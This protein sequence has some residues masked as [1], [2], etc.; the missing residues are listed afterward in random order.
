MAIKLSYVP[1]SGQ[2]FYNNLLQLPYDTSECPVDVFINLD[3]N[4][5]MKG[6]S[7]YSKCLELKFGSLLFWELEHTFYIPMTDDTLCIKPE[8]FTSLFPNTSQ[9]GLLVHS[10]LFKYN[11]PL[12]SFFTLQ[13]GY[14]DNVTLSLGFSHSTTDRVGLLYSVKINILDGSFI[15]PV[16]LR[17]DELTFS[18]SSTVF[19]NYFVH[20][21]GVASTEV[22]WEDLTVNINGWFSRLQGNL[23]DDLEMY[24]HNKIKRI[25][26]EAYS[27]K[28]TAD[29]QYVKTKNTYL[30]AKHQVQL[31]EEL[32]NN[33]TAIYNTSLDVLQTANNSLIQAEE[34][35]AN[36]AGIVKQTQVALD[37]ACK[38]KVC[39]MICQNTTRRRTVYKR[40]FVNVTRSCNANCSVTLRTRV[41]PFYESAIV[42]KFIWE[43]WKIE[44]KCGTR[45]CESLRCSSICKSVNVTRPIYNYTETMILR[46]CIVPC[47]VQEYDTTVTETEIFIDSCGQ[48]IQNTTCV[49][50]NENCRRE[51][52]AAIRLI[53]NRRQGAV[54][55]LQ[56][57]YE[58]KA[59]F[60]SAQINVSR[61]YDA[62]Q[63]ANRNLET[64]KEILAS[65]ES[66]RNASEKTYHV[67]IDSI[68]ADL[69]L[70]NL[71]QQYNLSEIYTI[72]NITFSVDVKTVSPVIFPINII[73]NIYNQ[74]QSF[75]VPFHF[76]QS[77][78]TQKDAIV[79]EIIN[80]I[81]PRSNRRRKRAIEPKEGQDEEQFEKHC[82]QIT[83]IDS[84][85]QFLRD[86]LLEANYNNNQVLDN[87]RTLLENLREL[88]LLP[89]NATFTSDYSNLQLLFNITK[90]EVDENKKDKLPNSVLDTLLS[91]I[92]DM[93]KSAQ[94]VISNINASTFLQ[95]QNRMEALMQTSGS[96]VNEEC[97]GFAD[98]LVVLSGLV[99]NVLSFGP[100]SISADLTTRLP[101]AAEKLLMLATNDEQS[102]EEALDNLQSMSSIINDM[103]EIGYWCAKPPQITKHPVETT[104]VPVNGRL[105]LMCQGNSK[106]PIIYQWRKD[107]IAL[108]DATNETLVIDNFQIFDEG[109]YSCDITND[110]K[111]VGSTN[112][113][114]HAYELPQFYLTPNSVVAYIGDGNGAYFTCN[115]TSRP[116]PG[117]KWYHKALLQDKWEEIIGEETNELLIRRPDVNHTGWYMCM[118]YNEYGN[119][120]SDPVYLRLVS[121]T[122]PV[123]CYP[124]EFFLNR[125][126]ETGQGSQNRS[127]EP[128]EKVVYN[129]LKDEIDFGE[130]TLNELTVS[131]SNT[132]FVSVHLIGR[133]VTVDETG[134][135][136]L[137]DVVEDL[138]TAKGQLDNVR[139]KMRNH[140]TSTTF[141]L[142]YER[143]RY[144]SSPN[145][146]SLR[147]PEI[148]C[149]P[150]QELHPN[151]FLCSKLKYQYFV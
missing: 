141:E 83:G 76:K 9:F 3:N 95:W 91:I 48:R 68:K 51:I 46:S 108:P 120:T 113:S 144:L 128:I 129:K 56:E 114:V 137:T 60:D 49:K 104:S 145:S 96:V 12:G 136:P 22:S 29:K 101:L 26:Q 130:V 117:W 78:L 19:N 98:C 31:A 40:V 2:S 13:Q 74:T 24:V 149:P 88:T 77:F 109:N 123:L 135:V 4:K 131:G 142:E 102:F 75:T 99:E 125:G 20:M 121:V 6:L 47:I 61:A 97:F 11:L 86:S 62:V 23:T 37:D 150:G 30:A 110:V 59:T 89:G 82:A 34:K 148:L 87:V 119:I 57:R 122:A 8:N 64:T 44:V 73:T 140:F 111:T 21:T 90:E 55:P 58:A 94:D 14:S 65:A 63:I 116:D 138:L 32:L 81:N 92:V 36:P 53:E 10:S 72:V 5:D 146:F 50:E 45:L 147:L 107:G 105:V 93:Q 1:R 7:F 106:L 39:G 16:I 134:K 118:A 126:N 67:I 143:N 151:T 42:W 85:L 112:S 69:V 80:T 100:S 15:A 17:N 71:T 27:R 70:Y 38:I 25:S 18:G 28:T 115:A 52:E 127:T 54:E 66:F 133:N 124:I 103:K 41:P 33:A 132:L 35:L 43:C 79:D 84:F 139:D